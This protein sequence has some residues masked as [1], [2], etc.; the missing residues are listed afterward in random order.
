MPIRL[1]R[2]HVLCAVTYD[3][4]GYTDAFVANTSRIAYGE[5]GGP[6]GDGKEI[7]ITSSADVICA[8][9]PHRR[10]LGCST[11]DMIDGLDLMHGAVLDLDPGDRLSWEECRT[12]V[13][14]RIVPQ[15]LNTLC[16]GCSLLP[17]GSCQASLARQLSS[18]NKGRPKAAPEAG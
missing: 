18:K 11:N 12:R 8:S 5:L 14:D 2:H 10:G 15:D 16:A 4:Q 7:L 9:C 1:R 13:L 17:S 6:A 3:G